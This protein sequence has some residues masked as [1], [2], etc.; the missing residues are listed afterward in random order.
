MATNEELMKAILQVGGSVD[1]VRNEVKNVAGKVEELSGKMYSTS[2][3]DPGV[4][5]R[6]Q[7][8]ET[9]VVAMQRLCA[10]R[11]RKPELTLWEKAKMAAVLAL[12]GLATTAGAAVAW[13]LIML[14]Q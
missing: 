10:E 1:V 13:K 6:T 5:V 11:H 9:D 3:D 8:L 4:M 7:N 12:I 2:K 14:V